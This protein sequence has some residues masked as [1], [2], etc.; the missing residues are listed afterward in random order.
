MVVSALRIEP[1]SRFGCGHIPSEAVPKLGALRP[2]GESVSLEAPA[3]PLAG[4]QARCTPS[5]RERTSL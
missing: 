4:L 5:S 2:S 1:Y 3:L